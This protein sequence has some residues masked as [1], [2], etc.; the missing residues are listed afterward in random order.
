MRRWT[1]ILAFALLAALA[2]S[3]LAQ[4]Q[5]DRTGQGS[6]MVA[7]GQ[8]GTSVLFHPITIGAVVAGAIAV[9]LVVATEDDSPIATTTVSTTQ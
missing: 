9:M 3:A 8:E 6:V 1:P 7:A 2:D 5:S 4:S